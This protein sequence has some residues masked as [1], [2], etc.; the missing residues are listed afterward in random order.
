MI[1][2]GNDAIRGSAS[3]GGEAA[4]AGSTHP[5]GSEGA[6]APNPYAPPRDAAEGPSGLRKLAAAPW[7]VSTYF[8]EG[9]PF[10]IV[11]QMSGELFTALGTSL[12]AVGLTSLYGFAWNLKFLWSPLVDRFGTAR[13]W[14]VAA[15][16]LLGVLVLA[17]AWPASR[18]DIRTFVIL[19]A[20]AAF[21]AAT[22]DVA[23]DGFY[24]R[25]LDKQGQ[26][27]FSGLRV[28]AYRA[29]LFVGSSALI[30]L[31]GRSSW[32]WAFAVAGA[33]LLALAAG[34][35]IFLPPE[36]ATPAA[37]GMRYSDAFVTFL[38]QPRAAVILAFILL[39]NAGDALMFAMSAPFLKDL[40][41][42]TDAR[43]LLNGLKVVA[44]VGGSLAGAAVVARAG[45]KRALFP[46]AA[47]QS[48]A[49][50]AFVALAALR[51]PTLGIAVTVLFEQ[52]AAGF[53]NAAFVVFLMRR[54]AGE[55][56][57]SHFAIG[58]ALMSV[59]STVAG[60]VSGYL[61]TRLGFTLFF[62]LAFAASLPGVVL[63]R[64]VPKE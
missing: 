26:T 22:N 11:R 14:L 5:P 28:A 32:F 60:A 47:G 1:A 37:A 38:R 27:S 23:V 51:P 8:A 19:A 12:G 16:V 46:I 25:A 29:A 54:C 21:L 58:T 43:G 49:I 53:G 4:D 50:L 3:G 15:Q 10:S 9:L 59:A 42:Q 24:L 17:M 61:A 18:G 64:V 57:A 55:Y 40:G 2:A 33:L 62:L 36:Q 52:F 34:H 63:A 48:L 45:L 44:A 56:K 39:Y 30:V 41:F 20:I 31:A 6:G 13:R 35:A 7:V